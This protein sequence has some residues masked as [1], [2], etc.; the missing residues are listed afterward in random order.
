MPENAE[1]V[2]LLL[3]NAVLEHLHSL[4]T[5]F[6]NL[7]SLVKPGGAFAANWGPLWYTFSGDHIASELGFE[8]GYD[9]VRLDPA[10]YLEWYRA[11]PRNA[12]TVS[13][14]DP[15][16]LDLGLA[17]FAQYDEYLVEIE[18]HFG[19]IRW[20]GWAVSKA[21]DAWHR[22]FPSEWRA[23]LKQRPHVSPLDLLLKSV[24]VIARR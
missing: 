2:D 17:S 11:H 16:W 13:R 19:A 6:G 8:H 20:L 18:R 10:E 14:G 12:S 15:T 23:M 21:G 4:R 1:C 5:T 9:H 7:Q 3:S 22:S 24:A